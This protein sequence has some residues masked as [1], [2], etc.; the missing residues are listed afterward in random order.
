MSIK[1]VSPLME[2]AF[3]EN[4]SRVWE[5]VNP[6]SGLPEAMRPKVD[7]WVGRGPNAAITPE[8]AKLAFPGLVDDL[9]TS[10]DLDARSAARAVA[11]D[12]PAWIDAATP[13]GR[14]PKATG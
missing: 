6:A 3:N 5:M 13:D 11:E 9:V 14:L 2:K 8:E 7:S 1:M 10:T 12:L 4:P